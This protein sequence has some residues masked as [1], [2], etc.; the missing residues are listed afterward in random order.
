MIEQL[1][2][3]MCCCFWHY[4]CDLYHLNENS[5]HIL[6][7]CYEE[8]VPL[9]LAIIQCSIYIYTYIIYWL[10]AVIIRILFFY[11]T[12]NTVDLKTVLR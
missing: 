1:A 9:I 10:E 2:F 7:I 3:C 5:V 8:V 11:D 6:Y 4:S 12:Y